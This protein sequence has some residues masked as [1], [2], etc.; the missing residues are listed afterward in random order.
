M[1]TATQ[2]SQL[3]Y[4]LLGG[5][6]GL[7][8]LCNT[9]YDIMDTLPE[10]STIRKMHTNNLEDIKQK[11]YEYL[12]GWLGGPNLYYDRHKTICLTTPH[13][14]YTI[15]TRERDQWLTCMEKALDKTETSEDIKKLLMPAFTNLA[16]FIRN[17]D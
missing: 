2:S 9:F 11:L 13:Q 6:K 12:S 17:E 3:P 4:T 15:G 5:E 7:R 14:A 8:Q 1:K 10:A 16:D